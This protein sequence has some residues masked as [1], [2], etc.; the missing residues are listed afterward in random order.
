MELG[1]GANL[2]ILRLAESWMVVVMTFT[3]LSTS[4]RVLH[5]VIAGS[6]FSTQDLYSF[7]FALFSRYLLA[8]GVAGMPSKV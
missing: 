7:Q 3:A 2:G 6:V 5:G 1:C 4:S 8:G